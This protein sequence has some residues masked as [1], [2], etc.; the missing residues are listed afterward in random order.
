MFF[1]V[2]FQVIIIG[3]RFKKTKK[4]KRRQREREER[5]N[6]ILKLLNKISFVSSYVYVRNSSTTIVTTY[7]DWY[8]FI[9][10]ISSWESLTNLI[11]KI[12]HFLYIIHILGWFDSLYVVRMC[13]FK[14]TFRWTPKSRF[15]KW[16]AY[17]II[18]SGDENLRH[19]SSRTTREKFLC[20]PKIHVFRF[21][22]T[23]IFCSW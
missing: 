15:N 14:I 19:F 4:G 18:D 12:I 16:T 22:S 6:K 2:R 20:A 8:T 21:V 5:K 7:H 10:G 23:T 1:K 13:L 3:R 11:W 9:I 17:I